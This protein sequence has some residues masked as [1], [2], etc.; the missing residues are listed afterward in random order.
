MLLHKSLLLSVIAVFA[1]CIFIS[2]DTDD[3]ED[4]VD[5]QIVS[6]PIDRDIIL[7]RTVE[8]IQNSDDPIAEHVDSILQG[9][10]DA[11][12]ISTGKQAIDLNSDK[13]PDI[14]F[15]IIDLNEFNSE[16]LP[17]SFDDLAARAHPINVE[18]LDNSTYGYADALDLD[19]EIDEDN[20]WNVQQ[21]IVL[22]TFLTAGQ[23]KGAGDKY[24]GFRLKNNNDYNYGWIKINCSAHNDSLSI[25][26]YA[27]NQNVNSKILAGQTE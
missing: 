6:S 3:P 19:I 14:S 23:F 27:Y 25:L 11:D 24:L 9:Y 5:G 7:P 17:S 12:F 21:N 20:F 16:A 22:G 2:C 1:S 15:D 10:I 13:F 8:E 26:Q 18:I 4:I